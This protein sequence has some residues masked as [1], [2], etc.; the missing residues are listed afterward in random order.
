MK[1]SYRKKLIK[2]GDAKEKRE[3]EKKKRGRKS[4]RKER[5]IDKERDTTTNSEK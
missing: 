2:F 3:K 4:R 5:T 1:E